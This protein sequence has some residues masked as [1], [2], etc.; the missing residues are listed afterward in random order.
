MSITDFKIDKLDI[1]QAVVLTD[2]GSFVALIRLPRSEMNDMVNQL[3][4]Q[5]AA[6]WVDDRC[7]TAVS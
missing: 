4:A 1:A 7:E 2:N 5:L 6:H 3:S